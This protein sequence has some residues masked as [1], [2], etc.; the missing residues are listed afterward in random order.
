MLRVAAVGV[1]VV[2]AAAEVFAGAAAAAETVP[3]SEL[4]RPGRVLL[5]RH[6]TAPGVGDPPNFALRDCSTQ[7]NLDAAGR[8]QAVELGKRLARAGVAHASVWSS[9]W[10]RC[11]ETAW[12]LAIGPVAELPALNS[13]FGR[14][15]ERAAR[16]AELRAFLVKLPAE[17]PPVVLV[18]HQMTISALIG[19]PVASGGGAIVA[20]D[21]GDAP[22]IVGAIEAN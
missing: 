14:E 17:G 5:L 12:L 2:L 3:L 11:L 10:C 4:A 15:P 1:A 13:F 19:R 16:I 18:T 21:G 6:A 9:Q 7:R 20:L 22:R 8:A